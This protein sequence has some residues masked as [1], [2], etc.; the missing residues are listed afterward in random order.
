MG[1]DESNGVVEQDILA[2]NTREERGLALGPYDVVRRDPR[3]RTP[4]DR[5]RSGAARGRSPPGRRGSRV[6]VFEL[7][8]EKIVVEIGVVA[9]NQ[10]AD[11]V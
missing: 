1:G 7:R 6:V 10:P 2:A 4:C 9:L 8:I 11:G 3:R 5:S